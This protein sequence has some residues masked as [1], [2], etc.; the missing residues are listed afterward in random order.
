MRR[1]QQIRNQN[2]VMI[3]K[4]SDDEGKPLILKNSE[5]VKIEGIR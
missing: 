1:E 4:M 5:T 3:V 2:P